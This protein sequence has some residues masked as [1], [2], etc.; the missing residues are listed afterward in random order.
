MIWKEV[1]DRPVG[2]RLGDS[3][4][5]IDIVFLTLTLTLTQM[6]KA[7][8]FRSQRLVWHV[9]RRHVRLGTG[10]AGGG[11]SVRPAACMLK[12]GVDIEIWRVC[13]VSACGVGIMISN[14]ARRILLSVLLCTEIRRG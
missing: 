12:T 5:N 8:T 2:V 13:C 10:A 6:L 4:Q 11:G 14:F 9:R 7:G 3:L 1:G